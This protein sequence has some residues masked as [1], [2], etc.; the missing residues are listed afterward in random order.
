MYAHL[1][2]LLLH[3]LQA[4]L[5]QQ[6]FWGYHACFMP[7]WST[8]SRPFPPSFYFYKC[9]HPYPPISWTIILFK[10]TS[11]SAYL[12]LLSSKMCACLSTKTSQTPGSNI[13]PNK[14]IKNIFFAL[15]TSFSYYLLSCLKD[16]KLIA[17][18]VGGGGKD[19]T[20]F[21]H[22]NLRGNSP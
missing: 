16:L 11:C 13:G 6:L 1:N 3:S 8:K 18:W 9:I 21:I 12:I 2:C 15:N 5:S 22:R 19:W 4:N 20:Y 10:V 7:I 14:K 17:G